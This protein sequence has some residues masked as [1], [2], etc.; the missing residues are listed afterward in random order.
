M[1]IHIDD[2]QTLDDLDC[3]IRVR[4]FYPDYA[5]DRTTLIPINQS[6]RRRNP[7]ALVDIEHDG[8]TEARWVFAKFPGF[9]SRDSVKLPY[10]VTL[11]CP[12]QS[13]S[14]SDTPRG[15]STS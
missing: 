14:R 13:A 12:A 3:K 7:A 4:K 15:L 2:V 11:D 1:A 5:M 9:Q 8:V 10:Q 6:D